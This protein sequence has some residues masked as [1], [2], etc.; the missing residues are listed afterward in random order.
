MTVTAIQPPPDPGRAQHE[1]VVA[2]MVHAEPEADR[3]DGAE[4]A[5]AEI[6]YFFSDLELCPRS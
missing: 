2:L 4:T 1:Q 3:G 6:R 5:A